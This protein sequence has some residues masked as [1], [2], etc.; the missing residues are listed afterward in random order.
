MRALAPFVVVVVVVSCVV[1]CDVPAE[2]TCECAAGK[3]PACDDGC[4]EI[5]NE[6]CIDDECVAVAAGDLDV[7]I[8]VSIDRGVANDVKALAIALVDVRGPSGTVACG[9]TGPVQDAVNVVAGNRIEVSGGP[10]HPDLR[11]GLVPAGDYL[12]VVDGLDAGA[13]VI[14][15]GCD[16]L[17]ISEDGAITITVAP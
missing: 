9:D 13:A 15:T 10:F 8:T 11:V 1:G 6:L 12:V 17:A 2:A 14:A 5:A 4:P 3:A 7:A 16:D